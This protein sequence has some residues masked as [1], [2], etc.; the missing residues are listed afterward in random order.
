MNDSKEIISGTSGYYEMI[1]R[2]DKFEIPELEKQKAQYAVGSPGH[3]AAVKLI[4]EK[5]MQLDSKNHSEVVGEA[6]RANYLAKWAIAIAIVA[7]IVSVLGSVL[8]LK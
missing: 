8:N 5:Q 6:K 1:F 3:M 7:I 4:T 2:R